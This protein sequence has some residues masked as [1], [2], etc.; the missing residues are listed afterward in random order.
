MKANWSCA[1][2]CILFTLS[3]HGVYTITVPPGSSLIANHL[4]EGGNTLDEVFPPVPDGTQLLKWNCSTFQTYTYDEAIGSWIPGG[5][6]LKPGEGAMII[7]SSGSS[8]NVTFIGTA[9]VPVCP[10]HLPCG[11]DHENLVSRQTASPGSYETIT[12]VYP[13][14]G[15]TLKRGVGL[16][17][18]V[19]T[20][21]S[22]SWTP[23]VPSVRVGE[24]V[25]VYV[26]CGSSMFNISGIAPKTIECGA[27]WSFD[28]PAVSSACCSNVTVTLLSTVSNGS[29]PQVAIRTWL[30]TDCATN[31]TTASQVVTIQDTTPPVSICA[32]N[33]TV[34]CGS[35]WTFDSPIV[36]DGCCTNV[37]ISVLNTVTNVNDA[38]GTVITRTWQAVDCCNNT[39]TCS[40]V[41]TVNDT[42][43]PTIT[44][45]AAVTV[46]CGAQVPP[47]N[48]SLVTASDNC[49][50]PVTVVHVGDTM[51][52]SNC[53]N[54]F[55][56]TRT[57]R[58]TDACGNSATCSQTITVNDTTPPT[59]T[60][61]AAVTVGCA[62]EVPPP[63]VN[64][65]T[66]SDNCGG[67]VTVTHVG[68]TMSASNCL[69]Q[70]TLTRTYRATD[71]CGNSATCAQTIT[72]NDTTPP[73]L[74]CPASITVGCAA[75][76]PP[77]S[78]SLVT[79]SDNCG[80]PVALVHVGD[81]M[82]ASNCLNQFA[83]TRT[84][85]ATDACGNSAPC[86]QTITVNDTTPPTIT[87][88]ASI[89]VSCAAE[90]P[91]PNISLVTASDNCGGPVTVVHVGDT[92][93]ASNCLNQ[94]TLTRTYRATDACG[95]SATCSQTIAVNDTT[96]PTITCP[97]AVTVN[98]AAL[99]PP[100]TTTGILA[101]DNCGGPVTVN[102]VGDTISA[103]NC[104]NHFV[105]SRTYR[106]TDI[107]GNSATCIQ[108]IT[109]NDTK[110][111]LIACAADKS[112]TCGSAWT[113]GQPTASDN[114]CPTVTITVQGTVT[115]G[116]GCPFLT[117]TRTWRAADCC[118]NS[119]TCSQTVTVTD[120][121]APPVLA[122]VGDKTVPCGS[123][124]TFDQPSASDACCRDPV[125]VVV[126]STTT[127]G[128]A[129]SFA[130]TR[131]WQATDCCGSTS[132]CT[133]I[134]TVVDST[135][136]ML[137]CAPDKNIQCGSVWDFD[138]PAA[139]DACCGNNV[140]ITV[141][142]TVTNG[143]GCSLVATRTWQ[144]MDCC[145]LASTC[146]QTV[147]V[148][149]TTPPALTCAPDKTVEP[150]SGNVDPGV[151][152]YT[153]LHDFGSS[154][155]GSEPWAGLVE[156]S[157]GDLYGVTP[158]GGNKGQGTV[159]KLRKDGGGYVILHEFPDNAT[160][161]RIPTGNLI[162]GSDGLLYGVTQ[163]G[164]LGTVFKL[165]KGGGGYG[166]LWRF[167][168]LAEHGAAPIGGLIEG[169]DGALFGTASY[170]GAWNGGTVFRVAKDG[171]FS[172]LRS[173]GTSQPD[174][175][176]PW[177][178]LLEGSDG[179]LYGT[180]SRGGIWGNGL[181][182][183]LSKQGD[184]YQILHQFD[185][186][187][188]E[189]TQ[190]HAGLVLGSDG[191]FYGTTCHGGTGDGTVFKLSAG[192]HHYQVLAN[193]PRTPDRGTH[194]HSRL[195]EGA[196]GIF[197][198]TTMVGGLGA[199]A[200]SVYRVD[201]G[202]DLPVE[203][204]QFGS[205]TEDGLTAW[206]DLV[207]GTDGA[208][209]GTTRYGGQYGG[210]TVYRLAGAPVEPTWSF[211]EP[212]ATDACCGNDVTV[213]VL[214]TVTNLDNP[215]GILITR[216]WQAT[217]CCG[218]TATCSQSVTL[219]D[220]TPPAL[221]CA[222]DK[223]VD[224]SSGLTFDE[225]SAYDD[226][227]AN[228]T[229][230]VTSTVTN[231]IAPLVVTRTWEAT[232][233]CGN[234]STCSQTVTVLTAPPPNDDC[235]NAT[236]ID[237]IDG[238]D[239]SICGTTVCASPSPAGLLRSWPQTQDWPSRTG[240]QKYLTL[241][242]TVDSPDVWYNFTS[243]C[244]GEVWI[245]SS[246]FGSCSDET[247]PE[248]Y[249]SVYWGSCDSLVPVTPWCESGG[250]LICPSL[251]CCHVLFFRV[252]GRSKVTGSFGLRLRDREDLPR[253]DVCSD[254]LEIGESNGGDYLGSWTYCAIADGPSDQACPIKKDF[255]LRY[256]AKCSETVRVNSCLSSVPDT[257]MA[258]Y[259]GTCD[260]LT[261]LR[262]ND[263]A[264]AGRCAGTRKATVTFD[265][266]V[267]VTYFIRVGV[268]PG[269]QGGAIYASVEGLS[270]SAPTTCPPL[271]GQKQRSGVP[272]KS[273]EIPWDI[274]GPGPSAC[275]A[276]WSCIAGRCPAFQAETRTPWRTPS[277]KTSMTPAPAGPF[278][279][280]HST[281]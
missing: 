280:R 132:T 120:N 51:S 12:G 23:S 6:T 16:G 207:K 77:P 85:R 243:T 28:S 111:P 53:L 32:T 189:G 202:N 48:I 173:F 129:C 201:P 252:S 84:Y 88:P 183:S 41:V 74:T 247:L 234:S 42:S 265:A 118:G 65:V 184:D 203:L 91:P 196:S 228:V 182:Y 55:T 87:C 239:V 1:V 241:S 21:S 177:A 188:S 253:G 244:G 153:I 277:P 43:P 71:V 176:E 5:G 58:A 24:A 31:T 96:P 270:G 3:A 257:V 54:Q 187:L 131:I 82:S 62:A 27:S 235:A 147:I 107:C 117:I 35:V 148:T 39:N 267:G 171:T 64:L 204:H 222:G 271:P 215:C 115:N 76:V 130:A 180:T 140:T 93:S 144:A 136:P 2:A 17:Q 250:L 106:A 109:V 97:A 151:A 221:I 75:E 89:T 141:L 10:I 240:C 29:C 225:P 226:G 192:D 246:A 214:G 33:K 73:T 69:N 160:D 216:T 162:E 224:C 86:T 19:Y 175:A 161:G 36:S 98:C 212:T 61:P 219:A 57:Y 150:T 194:P 56:L 249:L 121:G 258:I 135:P 122:R 158:Y 113:F 167:S 8:F 14:E 102:Y 164:D 191:D 242:A 37:T 178:S 199:A 172:R 181:L 119:S 273:L 155:D 262:C 99:V 236:P 143:T 256:T 145:G 211:D 52:A 46:G 190:P 100:A 263:D 230:T 63:N 139:S 259:T 231:A 9:H 210:G 92:M 50:G 127:N 66:A 47:P 174:G 40:Q 7:N 198:G 254:A 110:P 281:T 220:H 80:G 275:L 44:C 232:D 116:T 78:T 112:V 260:N 38:C 195:V 274:R 133:Q 245:N 197:Y 13:M 223:T 272:S 70:L 185:P 114:C 154:G 165:N 11:C 279:H 206:G 168:I 193:F 25:W 103:S 15:A 237:L 149:D 49:G 157:D 156:A 229:I 268:K 142:A 205:S 101:V 152:Q 269:E 68:D 186:G 81:T 126:L 264:T 60:C 18:V 179:L 138:Q 233:C 79:A 217:D 146:S 200:G 108:T 266:L 45:P 166:V 255:W 159:F 125:S 209:Y 123:A 248:T 4:D 238:T 105:L 251:A 137:T 163:L 128:T 90:V 276:A 30:F 34:Q 213:S 26:P 169:Q 59:I 94:F 20:F 278:G 104:P 22:G 72:V 124:W 83:L 170:G 134:V 208:L 261:L 95:N 67:P 227:C 218:N